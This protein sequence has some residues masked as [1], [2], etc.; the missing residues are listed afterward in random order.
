MK[1]GRT[2]FLI[3]LASLPLFLAGLLAFGKSVGDD[4]RVLYV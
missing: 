2:A 4:R 3:S 1:W